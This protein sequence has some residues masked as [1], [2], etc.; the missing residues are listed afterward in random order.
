MPLSAYEVLKLPPLRWSA[1]RFVLADKSIISVVGIAEHVLVSIKGLVFPIDFYILKMPPSDSERTSS[2][3]LGRPFLKTSWFKLDVFSGTYSFEI[4]GR[5]VSFNLD[6]DMRHPPEDHSIFRCDLIDNVV[7]KVHQD[8]FDGKSMIEDPSVGSSHVCEEDALSPPEIPDDKVRSHKQSADLKPLPTHLKY[9]FLEENQKFPVI[10]TREL[11]SQ[12]EEKLLN[13]LRRNKKAIEWSLADLVGISPQ[14]CEHQIFLEE[15]AKPI[16]QPQR[17]LN[18]TILEV[19]KKE[20]TRLLEADIIY[21]ISDSEWVSPVQVVPKKSGVT[22]IKNEHRE[23]IVTRVQNSWRVCIDYRR[24]NLATRKDHFPLPFIDQILDRLCS[25]SLYCFLDG[26]SGYF[27]IHIAPEDQ[28]KTTFTCPFGTYA[29][30]R[31]PFGLCNA[32]ATF[33]R[34]MM[35]IFVDLLEHCIE[36]FMDDFSIYGDSFDLCLDNIAKVLE[37]CTKSNLVLNFENCHFMV[38]QGI[39]LGHIV[40]NDGIS[41]DPTKDFSKVALPLSRLLQKDVEF[42]L[43][44]ECMEAF[45]KLKIV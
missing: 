23:L 1:A 13:V 22:T 9:A 14:V 3:L 29:Y 26:Y 28:E 18:P 15:G 45:D 36:V 33:Q 16:R 12:Q 5:E 4:D 20:A 34:Y 30:K 21:P 8:N 39:V 43:S 27:Q 37:M 38:R 31:M 10:I 40:S 42:D 6:E 24:L 32:P 7:A 11:T 41:V 2:I 44:E 35:S 17:R 19:V 25:K